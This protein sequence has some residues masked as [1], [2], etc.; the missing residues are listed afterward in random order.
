[1]PTED[2]TVL[3]AGR[4][5]HH[6][7]TVVTAL[8]HA[9][10]VIMGKTTTTELAVMEPTKTRNPHD[11]SRSPGGS[12]SGSAAAVASGMVPLAIG[13]QTNGSVIRP[14][15]FCGV[16]GYKPPHG[17]MSRRGVLAQSRTLDHVGVFAGSVADAALIGEL[18]MAYDPGD[19]DMR[20]QARH[21]LVDMAAQ[22]PPLPPKVAFARTAVWDWTEPDTREAFAELVEALGEHAVEIELPPALG[23]ALEMH[24]TI[25]TADMA[26]SFAHEYE[27]GRD[28]LSERLR[29]MIEHGQSVTARDY[30]RAIGRIPALYQT[31]GEVYGYYDAILTPAAAGQA[32]R[33]LKVTG[34]PAFCTTWTLLGMPAVTL[35]LLRGADGMPMGA[36]LI[37]ERGHD[38]RL[39]RT[40][41]WLSEFVESQA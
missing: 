36:Q 3:H 23:D 8:R 11:R 4:H 1:M 38:G 34:D 13:S 41:R 29:E 6:D 22:E 26:V 20:P 37:G 18:L 27:A 32:P 24:R 30:Q 25:H 31:L 2:G 33:D 12:S 5:P 9:G 35:Q 28:K 19:P 14:A 40:A 15:S 10:A 39:L 16:V 21:H 17:L 7:A